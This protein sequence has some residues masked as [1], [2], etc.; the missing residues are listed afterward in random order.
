[1]NEAQKQEAIETIATRLG[2]PKWQLDGLLTR[3]GWAEGRPM[4]EDHFK[5]ELNKWLNGPT[6]PAK[7]GKK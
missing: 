5:R 7:R 2:I 6:V 3:K 4:T 1:M